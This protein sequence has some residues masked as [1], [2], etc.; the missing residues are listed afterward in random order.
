MIIMKCINITPKAWL[1]WWDARNRI[2]GWV[3]TFFLRCFSCEKPRK[4]KRH[5]VQR[6]LDKPFSKSEE[7]RYKF[8]G[9]S[10]WEHVV[11]TDIIEDAIFEPLALYYYKIATV[12]PA[13]GV[14]EGFFSIAGFIF[15]GRRYSLDAENL[16]AI[17]LQYLW[18]HLENEK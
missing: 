12:I 2:P 6:W 15:D 13:E 10:W 8:D 14:V 3:S 16:K 18:T 4:N 7:A 5:P 9:T 1:R 11:Q 17:C